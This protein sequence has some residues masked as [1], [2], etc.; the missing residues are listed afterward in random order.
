VHRPCASDL[1][2]RPDIDGLRAVAVLSVIGFHAGVRWFPGGYAGVDIFFVISGFL[3]TS[4]ILRQ[5]AEDRFSFADFYARR[6]KRIFPAL[7]IVLAAV[8][9]FG[10][11]FLLPNEYERIGKHIVAGAGFVSNFA[12]WLESG[13]FDSAAGTKPL[14]HLWSLGIE[15]QFYL[16]WPP[17]LLWVWKRKPDA[18]AV[19][20]GLASISFAI[21]V[22][23]VSLWQ[24]TDMYFLPPIRFW[25]LLVGSALAYAH[26]FRREELEHL[27]KRATAGVPGS[28]LV[29]IENIQATIGLA[30][31]AVAVVVLDKRTLFPGWWAMA[32]TIGAALLISAGPRAW[33]NRK[34][35]A[36][37][38]FVFIGLISYP[39]YLWHWPLL[40]YTHIMTAGAPSPT[41]RIV[42]VAAAFPL[43]WLTFRMVEK[44]IRTAPNRTALVLVPALA[45]IACFGLAVFTRQLHARS[46]RYGFEKIIKAAAPEWGFPGP[47]LKPFHTALGYHF[48]QGDGSRKVLF[49]GDSHMEQYYTRIDRLLTERPDTTKG[50]VFVTRRRCLPIPDVE[51]VTYSECKGLAENAFSIGQ[52]PDIDTVVLGAAWNRYDDI[53]AP[54]KKERAFRALAVMIMDYRKMGRQVYLILPTPRGEAFDPAHLVRRSLR[55]LGFVVKQQVERSH[56]DASVEPIASQLVKVASS[57]GATVINPIDE[58]CR[59]DYCPTLDLDGMPVYTDDSH[60]RQTYVREHITFLDEI[61]SLPQ[62]DRTDIPIAMGGT[63]HR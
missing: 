28:R 52:R 9:A 54:G 15:E 41:V 31:I 55:D 19:A 26:L 58:L 23:L 24:A 21:N 3:I 22:M 56:A 13:Y 63:A 7:I 42:V 44:S 60:L 27:L 40:S 11:M 1:A 8:F 20:I 30:L 5:L 46:E 62:H 45:V 35:M 17:L 6:C 36:N 34:L 43:S 37:R 18:L 12:F 50:V 57:S 49:V 39:L 47:R 53:F 32:P 16:L 10:W 33:I 4:I 25:E 59:E 2:Y 48:A 14:L 29:S 51:G 61:V 38:V